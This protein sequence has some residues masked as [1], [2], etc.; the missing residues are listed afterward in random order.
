MGGSGVWEIAMAS[1]AQQAVSVPVGVVKTFGPYG[2]Q[3]EV[4][5][6]A[7]RSAAGVELVRVRVYPTLEETDYEYLSMLEDPAAR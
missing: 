6:Y 1:I 2:P 7:G 5:G 3:Y 4:L